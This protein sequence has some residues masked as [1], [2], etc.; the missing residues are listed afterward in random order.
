MVTTPTMLP[1]TEVPPPAPTSTPLPGRVVLIVPADTNPR[2]YEE[3]HT[4]LGDL[5]GSAG[6]VLDIRE[7]VGS[8]EISEDWQA[9]V[10]L[11]L[12]P[13][14]DSITA[15][16]PGVQF[17]VI[18]S[19]TLP[20]TGNLSIIQLSPERQAFAAGYMT[21][22]L[23]DD[24][25]SAALLPLDEPQGAVIREA[26]LNGAAFFCGR[27][28][29]TYAPIHSFPLASSLPRA[30]NAAAWQG[31]ADQMLF[32]IVYVMYV[33]P[34]SASPEL[35]GYLSNYGVSL[36]GGESPPD[37]ARA[38]WAATVRLDPIASLELLWPDLLAGSEGKVVVAPLI[39][40][41]I[42]P[43]VLT[44]GRLQFYEREIQDLEQGWVSPIS[45]PYP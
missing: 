7:A 36:V 34:E 44:P 30:S 2:L 1:A 4:L 21:V 25:R 35:L 40:T 22:L 6:M 18:D 29:S 8:S 37:E 20:P 12:P 26:F 43:A 11:G 28:L 27:C 19:T 33:A 39:V 5:T 41:D 23:A 32:S 13:D 14:L 3:A 10:Y 9:V 38:G 24:F 16:A 15:S 42:N 45:P 31:A 17:V